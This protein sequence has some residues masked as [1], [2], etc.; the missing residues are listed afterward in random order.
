[1]VFDCG[2]SPSSVALD[3]YGMVRFAHTPYISRNS[4]ISTTAAVIRKVCLS[5][6]RSLYF[7]ATWQWERHLRHLSS[8]TQKAKSWIAGTS[9]CLM[10]MPRNPSHT[11]AA[12]SYFI[13]FSAAPINAWRDGGA[14]MT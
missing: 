1:M 13:L 8:L 9:P 2:Q 11:C 7:S 5:Q 3:L 12:L 6:T 4:S 14:E 10:Y